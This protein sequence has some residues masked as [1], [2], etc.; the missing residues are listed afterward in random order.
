MKSLIIILGQ[1]R[2][3]ELTWDSFNRNLLNHTSSD[4]ALCIGESNENCEANPFWINA[5]YKWISKEYDDF[6]QGFEDLFKNQQINK[7]W[8]EILQVKDQWLGGVKGPGQHPGSAGI[9]IYFRYYALKQILELGLDKIYD[10]FIF[11]RSDYIWLSKHPSLSKMDSNYI[12]FPYGEF[13]G[14]LTDRHVVLSGNY[15]NSYLDLLSPIMFDTS[16]LKEEMR[17]HPF[18]QNWNLEKYI[19]YSMVRTGNQKNIRFFPFSM[20]SV[21]EEDTSTRWSEGVYNEKLGYF[22]KYP[23]EYTRAIITSKFFNKNNETIIFRNQLVMKL[24]LKILF[25][26]F[27]RLK[28]AK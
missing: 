18:K 27:N 3:A 12:W 24:I 13:H 19:Y 4:L 20:Y 25:K 14:G 7:N 22:L 10:R 8:R 6:G 11:T 17:K 21:R 9:L 28:L 26:V 2:A 16:T 23:D 15:I 1:A 5:N